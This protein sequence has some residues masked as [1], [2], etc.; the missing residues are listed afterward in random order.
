MGKELSL[1]TAFRTSAPRHKGVHWFHHRCYV[2]T[3]VK[4]NIVHPTLANNMLIMVWYLFFHLKTYTNINIAKIAR[5]YCLIVLQMT[6]M[7]FST[8]IKTDNSVYKNSTSLC[9]C[10]F[11]SNVYF[12]SIYTFYNK[13]YHKHLVQPIL[14]LDSILSKH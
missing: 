5:L 1:Y 6:L 7:D 10:N 13:S 12:G 11:F 4:I 8:V 2:N 14:N 9:L 3:F